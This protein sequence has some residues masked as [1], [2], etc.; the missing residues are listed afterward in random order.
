MELRQSVQ[1]PKRSVVVL[2]F[3]RLPHLILIIFKGHIG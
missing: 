2:V 3:L 1:E